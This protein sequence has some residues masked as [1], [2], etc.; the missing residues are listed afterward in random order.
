[1]LEDMND[2]SYVFYKYKSDYL[3]QQQYIS[4]QYIVPGSKKW[5]IPAL[6]YDLN[7]RMLFY[8]KQEFSGIIFVL[9][10]KHPFTMV[11]NRGQVY[12]IPCFT[13]KYT[14]WKCT[15]TSFMRLF[16]P[17]FQEKYSAYHPR[18]IIIKYNSKEGLLTIQRMNYE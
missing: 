11:H 14:G 5:R 17:V 3:V 12:A 2:F 16:C 1:M 8:F 18:V 6:C 7:L 4:T 13:Q 10:K 15:I 9:T